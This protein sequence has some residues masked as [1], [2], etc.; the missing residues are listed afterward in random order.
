MGNKEGRGILASVNG[1]F[2]EDQLDPGNNENTL[3]SCKLLMLGTGFSG[4]STLYYQLSKKFFNLTILG[5]NVKYSQEDLIKTYV[6]HIIRNILI[7]TTEIGQICLDKGK[8]F[9]NPKSGEY[10]D[11]L[12]KI[13]KQNDFYAVTQNLQQTKQYYPVIWEEEVMREVFSTKVD[14]DYFDGSEHLL[15]P[16]TLKRINDDGYVPEDQDVLFCR[17]KT[18]GITSFQFKQNNVIYE[19]NDVGGQRNERKKWTK[20]FTDVDIIIYL[21]SLSDYDEFVYE[22]MVPTNR[23]LEALDC[24]ERTINGEWFINTPVVLLFNKQDVLEKKMKEKDALVETFPEYKGGQDALKA[25]EFIM[26]LF[27]SKIKVHGETEE[28]KQK[29]LERIKELGVYIIDSNCVEDGFAVIREIT[30]ELLASNS[31]KKMKNK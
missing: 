9:K 23:M 13:V 5:R 4:K 27:K 6:D 19:I 25:Q 7:I 11:E 8:K 10:M 24:F 2:D 16:K 1:D 28:E 18:T 20:L 14:F 17:K 30:K 29:S 31:L 26:K 21:I 3:Y 22:A 15:S 12:L